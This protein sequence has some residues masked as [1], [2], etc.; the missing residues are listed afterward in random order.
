MDSGLRIRSCRVFFGAPIESLCEI[1]VTDIYFTHERGTY[2]ALYG[3]L[4]AGSNFLAPVFAGFINDGQGW[5]WVLY[6]CAIFCGIGFVFLFF[7]MEETNYFRNT[8]GTPS[9]TPGTSTPTPTSPQDARKA[10]SESNI[11]LESGISP[12]LPPKPRKTYL[13]KLKLFQSADLHKPNELKG[14]ALRPLI[15]LS[16]PVIFYAGF[17][18]GSNLVW[19][20]VLNATSSLILSGTYNFSASMVGL[21][22][23]SPLVGVAIGCFYTGVLGDK[24]VVRKARRNGGILEPEHRLWL[25]APSL[26]LIPGGLILWGVG[27]AHHVHWFGC[28]FAMGVVSLTNIIGLQ[29]S[30]SYCIDSYRALSGEAMVTVILVRNT[31]SFAVGYG[32]TPWVDGMGLQNAFIL[33]AFVGLAQCATVWLMVKWGK[34]FRRRSVGRYAKY[35]EEMAKSGMIH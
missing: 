25:F 15:F 32:I 12:G 21:S 14:M 22:Y 33:A 28:V 5:Q 11:A 10:T 16:F 30:V 18:Y 1:S 8:V 35:V 24:F 23:I 27:A 2:I 7:F 34:E 19:F 9:S 3:L 29:L 26:L 4:L 13:N 31:M 6:W 20:N 17:S